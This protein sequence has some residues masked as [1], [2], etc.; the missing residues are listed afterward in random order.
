M[1]RQ[2]I[3]ALPVDPIPDLLRFEDQALL[4]FTKCDLLQESPGS[5]EDIWQDPHLAK[6][7]KK[8]NQDG[9]WSYPKR[10]NANP[11]ENYD[12]LQTYRNLRVLIE[13][14]G[15]DK[16]KECVTQA[17]EFLLGSQSSEGDF[18]GIFGSQY[19]PHYTAGM[20]EL[21]IKAG[22]ENDPRVHKTFQWFE[23][24]RQEDGGWAWPLRTSNTAYQDAI[25]LDYPVQSDYSKPFSHAL[26]LFVIRAYAV[27]P[28]F[29]ESFTAKKTGKL[30]K[31]RFFKADK[32]ADRKSVGYWFKFQY[33]FWWGNLLTALD[34]L[35]RL[36]F[37]M[38][39]PD[40][41]KGLE[42]FYD[43]QLE[44]GLW[45]TGYGKGKRNDENQA[46][47][48]LAVCRVIKKFIEMNS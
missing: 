11:N 22:Y 39:D 8:Q 5:I 35:S 16:N 30:I 47:V 3:K 46:W 41:N 29:R 32:Y 6:L 24:T 44:S 42:W 25:V 19:A 7:L 2:W 28:N 12:L 37:K 13:T 20:L 31:S 38:D 26:S 21:I 4:Y 15:M 27:H 45:P 14:Y 18:R 23:D 33:P 40:V 43:N 48:G 9:S 1:S 10:A 17:V 36:G 34:S